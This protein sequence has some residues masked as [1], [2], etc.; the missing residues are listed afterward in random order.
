MDLLRLVKVRSRYSFISVRLKIVIP[1][2]VNV[3]R[4]GEQILKTAKSSKQFWSLKSAALLI[5]VITVAAALA[6]SKYR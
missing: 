6:Y 4:P 5:V 1:C 3:S 2:A